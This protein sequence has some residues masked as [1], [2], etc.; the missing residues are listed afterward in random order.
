MQSVFGISVFIF[1]KRPTWRQQE[2]NNTKRLSYKCKQ[3][4]R[5]K[6]II[7]ETK[8]EATLEKLSIQ[9][10]LYYRT[11]EFYAKHVFYYQ[12]YFILL[13]YTFI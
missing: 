10:I 4:K 8:I 6:T 5:R 12:N 9:C 1:S 13:L 3:H 11:M 7:I 2:V